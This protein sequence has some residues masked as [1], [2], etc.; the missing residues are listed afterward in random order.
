MGEAPKRGV[1]DLGGLPAG[2]VP[3]AEHALAF[4]EKRIDAIM[5]LLV[6]KELMTVDELRRG[7]ESLPAADYERL[8]YYERWTASIARIMA[9]RGVVSET[10]LAAREAAIAARAAAAER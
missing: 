10:E 3:R 9:E 1:H 6:R 8:S 5:Q 4:W 2:P 7:I